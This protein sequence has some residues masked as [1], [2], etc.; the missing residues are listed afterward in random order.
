MDIVLN[1]YVN[2][3]RDNFSYYVLNPFA[4][5]LTKQDRSAALAASIALG[6][7]TVGLFHLV[8]FIIHRIQVNRYAPVSSVEKTS[9]LSIEILKGPKAKTHSEGAPAWKSLESEVRKRGLHLQPLPKTPVL[10]CIP[11][12]DGIANSIARGRLCAQGNAIPTSEQIEKEADRISPTLGLKHIQRLSLEDLSQRLTQCATLLASLLI[13]SRQT[14]YAVGFVH[15][16]SSQWVTARALQYLHNCQILPTSQF[17]LGNGSGTHAPKAN[18]SL[19]KVSEETL[20]LFD[21]YSFSGEPLMGNLTK[22]EEYLKKTK[23][24]KTVYLILPFA[25]NR[26]IKLLKQRQ[27]PWCRLVLITPRLSAIPT[28]SELYPNLPERQQVANYF[29]YQPKEAEEGGVAANGTF[30]YCDWRVPDRNSSLLYD[31]LKIKPPYAIEVPAS[32]H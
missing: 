30:A 18:F 14:R 24:V 13:R 16:E 8:T 17:S 26:V 9:G 29:G 21:D 12:L 15:G 2:L 32:Q 31:T 4:S 7:F 28:L 3:N 23:Q 1:R 20:V 19:G 10:H 25:T 11:K 22:I 6:V 27:S 5:S